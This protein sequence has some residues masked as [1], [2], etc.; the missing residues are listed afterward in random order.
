MKRIAS[1]LFSCFLLSISF[2]HGQTNAGFQS[3]PAN[4]VR[5]TSNF[6]EAISQSQTEKKPVLILFTGTDWCPACRILER[7]VISNPEFS[8]LIGNKFIFMKAEFA[9]PY[10]AR[11]Q[12]LVD[13]YGIKQFPTFAVINGS[14]QLLYKVNYRGGGTPQS[15][16]QD[17]SR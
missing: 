1:I 10:D 12:P 15:Y 13:R 7:S 4:H 16:A 11:Y 14:G 6:D 3:A 2:V 5:W 8:R 17:L 9:K